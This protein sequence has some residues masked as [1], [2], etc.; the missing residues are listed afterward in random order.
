MDVQLAVISVLR[1]AFRKLLLNDELRDWLAEYASYRISW[2]RDQTSFHDLLQKVPALGSHMILSLKPASSP[3]GTARLQSP[4]FLT[5]LLVS[6][7]RRITVFSSQHRHFLL[8]L[9]SGMILGS[10]MSKSYGETQVY[11]TK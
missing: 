3:L 2:L 8:W 4:S 1:L 10:E 6:I 11:A 5:T 7:L 9:T